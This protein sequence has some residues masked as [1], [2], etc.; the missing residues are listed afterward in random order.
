MKQYL[1]LIQDVFENGKKRTD[2]TGTGTTTV[3]GRMV[4]IDLKKGFPLLT[5]KKVHLH[6][7]IIE[8]LW[9][10]KGT[11]D[12]KYLDDNKVTIWKGWEAELARAD[13]ERY[14]SIGPLYG[15]SWIAFPAPDG[16]TVNQIERLIREIKN[17]PNSRRL[18]VSA[19]NPAV[20]PDDDLS[21][22]ENVLI[23]NS[24]LAP[25]HAF[26]QLHVEDGKL[27]CMLTQ[28]SGDC[29]LGVPFNWASYAL[30]TH[31]IA[32]QCSLEVGELVWSGGNVHIYSNHEEQ[33]RTQLTRDTRP[34]PQLVI[35]RKPAS[36]FDYQ[37]D[38]FEVVGYDPHPA[39]K[40]KVAI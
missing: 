13:G 27:S 22:Q 37:L 21:P 29:F 6:S 11:D 15:P 7:I 40:G 32:Q 16:T 10:L 5:T 36:I 24:A 35:K 20:L 8:L 19:W 9:F 2:R 30:L 18:V 3:F 39:L 12:T 25:C 26:F 33:L 31:M 23:G 1:E 17:R 14:K 28:R 4:R 34:L 38:D